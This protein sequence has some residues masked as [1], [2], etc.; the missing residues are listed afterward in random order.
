[1]H[2]TAII[3]YYMQVQVCNFP[4]ENGYESEA[5]YM[6]IHSLRI[7]GQAGFSG[8]SFAAKNLRG[9]L[10]RYKLPLPEFAANVIPCSAPRTNNWLLSSSSYEG[11]ATW[12]FIRSEFW[13]R[14]ALVG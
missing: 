1:M 6:G 9:E 7:L 2:C 14:Q 12:D 13:D 5:R 11:G 8:V 3:A 4:P 10:P